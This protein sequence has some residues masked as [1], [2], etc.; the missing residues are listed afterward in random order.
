[1]TEVVGRD[2]AL[3]SIRAFVATIADSAAALVLEG[4]AG[5]GKTTLWRAAVEHAD[6]SGVLVLEAQPVES[7]TTLSFAGLGDLLD[8][9]LDRVLGEL[10]PVRQR[11]LTR[12]LALGDD[13][14]PDLDP[15]ALR[16]AVM[17][18]IRTLA[19][20]RPVLIAI[21]DSQWLDYAS[22]AAL[23]YGIRRFRTE[24]IGLLLSR[25]SG[26]E[27][28]LLSELLRSPAGE[29]FTSIH[30]V[31]LGKDEL[32]RVVHEHLGR[33]LPRPLLVEVHEAS[34]GNPFYALEIVRMLQ[35]A[36][37]SIEAGRPLPVPESL[38]DLVDERLAALPDESGQFLLA[39]A[40]HAHPTISITEAASG[41]AA[42][43]GLNPAVE[44]GI[45][46]LDGQRIRFT[47]PL[48]AAAVIEGADRSQRAVVHVR[49]AELLEDPE[50][51]AWQL[52]ACRGEAD[53]SVA[54]ALEDASAHARAR[55][56]PRPAAL[57][58]DR[59]S[60]LTPQSH[61]DNA[62]RRA[63]DAAFLHFEAG[64]SRRAEATLRD[65]I[66]PMSAGP[67]RA[68]AL[69]VLARI[70]L[71]EA[72]VEARELFLQVVDEAGDD[73]LTLALAHEGVSASSVWMFERLDEALRH[74]GTAC[75][76]ATQLDDHALLGDVLMVRVGVETLLG[77]TEAT[78]TA[79]QALS[80]QDD[81]ADARVLDQP[82]LSLAEC[83]I[84][85]DAYDDAHAALTAL[86][87]RAEELGD[88]SARPWVLFLLGEV[89]LALGE[90]ASGLERAQ[91]GH[92]AAE[93]T[94]LP[95]FGKRAQ[96][97]ESLAL[98][99]LGRPEMTTRAAEHLDVGSDRF[100]ALTRAAAFGHLA[101]SLGRPNEAI[102][103]LTAEVDFVRQER[104]VEPG[105]M[106]LVV[107]LVEALLDSGRGDE[108]GALLEWYEGNS[109]R[110]ARVSALANCA[111]CRGLLASQDGDLDAAFAAFEEALG[112]F[113]RIGAALW[114]DRARAELK[115][116]S[117]RAATP[118]ALTPAE[119]RVAALV[120]DGK[121]NREVA[122][123][124][125]L[126]DRTVEGHLAHIFG[127][128]GIR[129]RT[130]LAGALQTRGIDVSNTGDSP[131]SA[132]PSAP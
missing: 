52:A 12:A 89:E 20:D 31:A 124:L 50:A 38:H 10:P 129:H 67:V 58:L 34:A 62:V 107:D 105:A 68:R 65:V 110:L 45:V 109:R 91:K 11:A 108:A 18:A 125:Y 3:A 32:G 51:R 66:A 25:R 77:S 78:A 127:K 8:P 128:L 86:L 59:A 76:L 55:G 1:M 95:L 90:L 43:R 94:G 83:W 82:L 19:E 5:M 75:D 116:I 130:E 54:Q 29:R 39:A 70:R 84:W 112:V 131:V 69:V 36:G 6:R 60:E 132:E 88:E 16:V 37:F 101:L 92:E 113:E 27:S 74:A 117:G 26:L 115:R 114:A 13:D 111:R 61:R 97:L 102:E 48:L 71:Y 2:A 63:V 28:V 64:D 96:A 49:L 56:A 14:Q 35:R 21:D 23:A 72:P 122:A 99:Q 7:E 87:A 79:E 33:S 9:V 30:V 118:G 46:E 93:Q 73:R 81:A 47:H 98:A 126:S 104:I 103:H 106:R 44:A 40:A 100:L 53:E 119:K 4:E 24:H 42:D 80:L 123:A 15:R 57:L 85:T 22:S 41:V 17:G 121:T 120:C